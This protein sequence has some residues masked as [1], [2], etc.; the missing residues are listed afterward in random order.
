MSTGAA[1]ERAVNTIVNGE[2]RAWIV[3]IAAFGLFAYAG[4]MVVSGIHSTVLRNRRL[5]QRELVSGNRPS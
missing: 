2:N 1:H 5:R 3:P 4:F